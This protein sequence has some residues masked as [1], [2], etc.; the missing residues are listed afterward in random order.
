MI[1]RLAA[2]SIAEISARI[3]FTSGFSEECVLFCIFRKRV[4]T[5]R[6]RSDRFK[7]WR[8][9]LAADLVLA[10]VMGKNFVGARTLVAAIEIVKIHPRSHA[11]ECYVRGTL[12]AMTA[13]DA[14]A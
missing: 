4:T 8:A 13:R 1:P 11:A 9:R 3:R 2:L 12:C 14:A 7:V 5:L 10:I 6:L